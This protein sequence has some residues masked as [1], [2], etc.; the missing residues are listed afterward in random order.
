MM[1]R[2]LQKLFRLARL[3][4]L[5]HRLPRLV[6]L[7]QVMLAAAGGVAR[8]RASLRTEAGSVRADAEPL[9]HF[10]LR[11]GAEADVRVRVAAAASWSVH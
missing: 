6:L 3:P 5:L 4:L 8:R 2:L 7:Q 11:I 1:F 10:L 9:M